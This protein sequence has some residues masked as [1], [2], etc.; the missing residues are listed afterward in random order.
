MRLVSSILL[1]AF[2]CA[3]SATDAKLFHTEKII[4]H[5]E[6]T[7]EQFSWPEAQYASEDIVNDIKTQS[8]SIHKDVKSSS[9]SPKKKSIKSLKLDKPRFRQL[10]LNARAKQ[11]TRAHAEALAKTSEKASQQMQASSKMMSTVAIQQAA[12]KMLKKIDDLKDKAAAVGIRTGDLGVLNPSG[13]VLP[14]V[15][16]IT[17]F[18]NPQMQAMSTIGYTSGPFGAASPFSAGYR[19]TNPYGS[20]ER[21]YRETGFIGAQPNDVIAAH[22]G[23]I[24]RG[25]VSLS[26]QQPMPYWHVDHEPMFPSLLAPF[27]TSTPVQL[28]SDGS[29][30]PTNMEQ[31]DYF[32]GGGGG[33][34]GAA[35]GGGEAGAAPATA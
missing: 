15:P 12:Q 14:N 24:K 33:A 25:A 26:P 6:P 9:V 7:A 28:Y 16:G 8:A 21:E 1:F 31:F 32:P 27:M 34:G 29:R 17:P 3:V 30:Y 20:P 35:A 10:R 19:S 2:S 4:H 18:I 11:H 5:S 23:G 13:Q 22:N